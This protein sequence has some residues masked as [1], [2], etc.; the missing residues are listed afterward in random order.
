MRETAL[1]LLDKGLD[2][3]EDAALDAYAEHVVPLVDGLFSRLS[4]ME[5]R[6]HLFFKTDMTTA[7]L[8]AYQVPLP[9]L[10]R[11]PSDPTS[12]RRMVAFINEN[13]APGQYNFFIRGLDIRLPSCELHDCGPFCGTPK[14]QHVGA[15]E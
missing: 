12:P 9:K 7:T 2:G 13:G 8:Q 4:E 6:A 1:A 5:M 14:T 15:G 3:V 10:Q 11:D